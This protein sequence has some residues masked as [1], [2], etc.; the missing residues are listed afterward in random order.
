MQSDNSMTTITSHLKKQQTTSRLVPKPLHCGQDKET[1]ASSKPTEN[2]ADTSSPIS[3]A[4]SDTLNRLLQ[5]IEEEYV[6][7]ES[8]QGDNLKISKDKENSLLVDTLA[9]KSL[10]I[11][12]Q[13][14]TLTEKVLTPFWNQHSKEISRKLLLPAKT[15]CVDSHIISLKG[16]SNSQ[17]GGSWFS[18]KKSIPQKKNSSMISFQSLLVSPLESMDS[19]VIKLKK[20]SEKQLELKTMRFRLFPSK[21]E[22]EKL[23]ILNDQYRWYYN[24]A[25]NLFNNENVSHNE[26]REKIR[27]Y[28]Y[29]KNGAE[30]I[31][32]AVH[33]PTRKKYFIPDFFDKV[34]T[35]VIRG[36]IHSLKGNVNSAL[37]NRKN[38]NI[39]KF[40]M[41]FK[42]RKKEESNG[43]CITFEDYNFPSFLKK[44]H[45]HYGYRTRD[46]KRVTI[47]PQKVVLDTK[48][49]GCNFFYEAS[50]DRYYLLYPVP[51]NYYPSLDHRNDKQA[52]VV[53]NENVIALDPG[54]RKF[55]TGYEDTGS[56]LTVGQN[57]H[58]KIINFLLNIDKETDKHKSQKL[59]RKVKNLISEL[60]WKSIN[61]LS[62]NFKSVILGDIGIRSILKSKKLNR[63]T[64]RV[65]SQYSFYQFKSKLAW[66]MSIKGGDLI[67]V[68]ESFTSKTCSECGLLTNVNGS[69]IFKCS[70]KECQAELDRDVNGA[71]NIMIKSLTLTSSNLQKLTCD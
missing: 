48:K 25:V 65:L 32:K 36:A 29:E 31:K 38:G 5:Q 53:E 52:S 67:M 17:K 61:Y 34:H 24:F 19:E 37:S 66:G 20:L 35:R 16:L 21:E 49:R 12:D 1:S 71:R 9:T 40:E 64:K 47:T 10:L 42:S 15:D 8:A 45:G 55:L 28:Y 18:M 43:F 6:T 22:R 56:I 14:S 13:V 46:H 11:L 57:S 3:N 63:Q 50:T 68:D 62:N 26:M 69:E 54:V 58:K 33:D 7:V 30:Y 23:R 70:N 44:I 60:H 51:V 2:T 59:W 41:G 39:E 4:Q 27:E